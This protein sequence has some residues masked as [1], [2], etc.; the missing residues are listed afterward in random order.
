MGS[1]QSMTGY[2]RSEVHND[3]G[4]LTVEVRSVNHRYLDISWRYPR[5]YAALEARMKQRVGK[6]FTRGR[7][8]IT[9]A[10]QDSAADTRVLSL[11]HTLAQQYYTALQELQQTLQVPGTIDLGMFVNLRELF[12][13]T[14]PSAVVVEEMWELIAQGLDGALAELKNMRRQEGE[15]LCRDLQERLHGM[16][17]HLNAIRERAG[18]VVVDYQQRL[19]QRV[20]E[21]FQQITLDAARVAQE[22]VLFAE[23]S[24]ITEELTRLEAHRQAFLDLLTS[25]E[26]VGR[27]LDFLVQEMHREVN[28]IGAKSND[29]TISHS[30][31]EL[32]NELERCREQIQNLE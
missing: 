5:Q 24:D 7:L 23:R 8:D 12:H 11:D 9:I 17:Q 26:A 13:I 1:M 6:H 16:T 32:K 21:W 29:I 18:Q 14:E 2:G 27:R 31:V 28:T 22:A 3:R 15:F 20:Q 19:A 25:S 30:V 4:V 10:Q